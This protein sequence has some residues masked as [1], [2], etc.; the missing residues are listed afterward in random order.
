MNNNGNGE[1]KT[2]VKTTLARHDINYYCPGCGR[3]ILLDGQ[4]INAGMQVGAAIA[5]ANRKRGNS[6]EQSICPLCAAM[7]VH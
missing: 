4:T 1:R 7:V 3:V 6:F 5:A 2:F